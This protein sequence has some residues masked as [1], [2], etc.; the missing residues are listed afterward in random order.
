MCVVYIYIYV[1]MILDMYLSGHFSFFNKNLM[2]FDVS[3][4]S[5]I[6]HHGSKLFPFRKYISALC[7]GLFRILER[8][9]VC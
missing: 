3:S 5:W 6:V 4:L 1:N 2:F 8:Q 9:H 7:S